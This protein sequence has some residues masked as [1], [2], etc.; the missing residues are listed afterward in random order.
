MRPMQTLA[1]VVC[2]AVDIGI[3]KNESKREKERT[4]LFEL[5]FMLLDASQIGLGFPWTSKLFY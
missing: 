2:S 3:L 1:R 4:L 5:K